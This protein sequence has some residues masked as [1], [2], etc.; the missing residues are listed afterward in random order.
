MG[1]D[2]V[3]YVPGLKH[4]F[5]IYRYYTAGSCEFNECLTESGWRKL[6]LFEFI[7]FFTSTFAFKLTVPPLTLVIS[8]WET[9][10]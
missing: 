1:S 9:H 10:Q 2:V 6:L 3:G 7:F 5:I 8:D 4:N